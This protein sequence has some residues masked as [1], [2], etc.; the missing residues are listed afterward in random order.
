MRFSKLR[1]DE[2][3]MAL[4]LAVFG[5]VVIGALVA[6]SFFVGRVEQISGYN[7]TWASQAGEAA[8]AG[9]GYA[10]D[11]L[12]ALADFGGEVG[13]LASATF[14]TVKNAT[15]GEF[16]IGGYEIDINPFW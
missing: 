13:R 7:T 10:K 12:N 1:K 15:N 2:Q 5:L 3:G 6:G 9:L 4:I 8:E 11:A 14:D 16:S